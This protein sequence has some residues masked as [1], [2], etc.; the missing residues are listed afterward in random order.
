MVNIMH[1]VNNFENYLKFINETEV[2]GVVVGAGLPLELPEFIDNKKIIA[3]IISSARA[4]NII[5]KKNG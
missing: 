4:L 3:P 1:V 2:D 5:I